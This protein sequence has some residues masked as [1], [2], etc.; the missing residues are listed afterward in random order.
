MKQMHV[1]GMELKDYSLKEAMRMVDTFLK[2]GKVNTVSFLSPEILMNAGEDEEMRNYLSSVDLTVPVSTEI[3]K[4]SGIGS[5]ARLAEVED[6]RFYKELMQKISNE[7]RTAFVLTEKEE[8]IEPFLTYLRETAPGLKVVGW[9][10]FENLTGDPD[11]IVNEINSTFPDI[12]L[13]RLPSPKQ[14]QFAYE[15][16]AKL[17]AKL[18]VAIREDFT[19]PY[20]K[21]TTGFERLRQGFLAK[22]FRRKVSQFINEQEDTGENS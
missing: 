13:S 20:K 16:I 2:E 1:L 22:L 10:A 7:K 5:R 9:Y 21:K 14:E 11:Q 12:V 17:N 6:G 19:T 18:W 15:H 3:L 4:A 8:T